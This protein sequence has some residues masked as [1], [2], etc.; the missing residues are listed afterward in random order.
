MRKLGIA[1]FIGGLL[2]AFGAVGGME[3]Q[4]EASLLAQ[5]LAAASGLFLM[6]VGTKLIEE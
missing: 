6:F 2:I 3:Y 4:P 5:C 1:F